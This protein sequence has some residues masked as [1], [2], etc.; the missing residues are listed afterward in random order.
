M[1]DFTTAFAKEYKGFMVA[2]GLDGQTVAKKLGRSTAYVSE[3]VNGKRALD[4]EDVD[5]LA[6]LVG[7]GWTGRTLMIELARRARA[8]ELEELP[9]NVGGSVHDQLP[10]FG[11]IDVAAL[12]QS[13]VALAADERGGFEEE[14][15]AKQE[16][17]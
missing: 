5:A 11:K 2:A 3:R 7:G 15:E 17:P 4:T 14:Q 8:H 16:L 1:S 6:M 9:E 12:R 13:G 10:H